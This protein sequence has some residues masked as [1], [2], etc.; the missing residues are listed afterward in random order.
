LLQVVSAVAA[1]TQEL[2]NSF[3]REDFQEYGRQSNA[4]S[5]FNVMEAVDGQEEVLLKL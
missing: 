1:S 5:S 3:V 2:S 4:R